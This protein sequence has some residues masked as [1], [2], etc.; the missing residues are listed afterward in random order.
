MINNV[1]IPRY[2]A[3]FE[4]G[5]T[6]IVLDVITEETR[7]LPH[8]TFVNPELWMEKSAIGGLMIEAA[9][10]ARCSNY[11]KSQR[12][13]N[14]QEMRDFHAAYLAYG[15]DLRFVPE[16]AAH[17][18]R[19]FADLPKS[20]LN[21]V[22]A[23]RIAVLERPRLWA[24]CQRPENVRVHD[25]SIPIDSYKVYTPELAGF[26]YRDQLKD[27]ALEIS[28]ADGNAKYES[29]IAGKI[30]YSPACVEM[31]ASRLQTHSSPDSRI[32]NGQSVFTFEDGSE[33]ILSLSDI[34]G[35]ER[36]KRGSSWKT[37]SIKKTQYVTCMMLLVDNN[38]Q[39]YLNKRT[40]QPLSFRDIKQYG[41]VSSG[42][43]G[44]PGFLR[45]KFYHHQ[46]KTVT[47]RLAI[48][49]FGTV[50]VQGND[51]EDRIVPN[52]DW[53]NEEVRRFMRWIRNTCRIADE[54]TVKA[55]RKYLQRREEL[56]NP[57]FAAV[58]ELVPA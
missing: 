29:S 11:S 43:H 18:Y 17:R 39:E 40:G 38:G 51:G 26:Y 53:K 12:W 34:M 58:D 52:V 16:S 14:E 37:G 9:H 27:A 45:P 1:D 28:A 36:G 13:R 24:T 47:K 48:E 44:K 31:V 46:I 22:K 33:F 5:D 50:V 30:A 20:G 41:M 2:I 35:F 10:G 49:K 25:R 6:V 21:D 57:L 23:Y 32:V 3:D 55:M 42:F 15:V 19:S 54:Q 7:I 8:K 56:D 4:K